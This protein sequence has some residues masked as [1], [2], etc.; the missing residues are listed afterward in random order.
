MCSQLIAPINW[1]TST[2]RWPRVIKTLYH[3]LE[4]YK[5]RLITTW[6]ISKINLT[7]LKQTSF[8]IDMMVSFISFNSQISSIQE[9]YKRYHQTTC[10]ILFLLI[11]QLK[12]NSVWALFATLITTIF[13][14]VFLKSTE[15]IYTDLKIIRPLR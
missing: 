13:F 7:V 4:C 10:Q 6:K 1:V 5:M 11:K 9:N 8:R 15:N 12:R 2:N 14:I 3:K